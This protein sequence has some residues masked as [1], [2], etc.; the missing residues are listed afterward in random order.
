MG[1][2]ISTISG[3]PTNTGGTVRR[4][5]NGTAVDDVFVFSDDDGVVWQRVIDGAYRASWARVAS[6]GVD[7]TT[8]VTTILAH[9]DV[10]EIIFDLPNTEITIDGSVTGTGKHFRFLNGAK[11]VGSGTITGGHIIAD[12]EA[13][14]IGI[15]LDWKIENQVMYAKWFGAQ[16]D[17]DQVSNMGTND[18]PAIQKA[19]YFLYDP[20][21]SVLRNPTS[22]PT[23]GYKNL[24]TREIILPK[25]KISLGDELVTPNSASNFI[26]RGYGFRNTLIYWTKSG[27]GSGLDMIRI[28]NGQQ[29]K[30]V[31]F[32][33]TGSVGFGIGTPDRCINSYSTQPI[34]G[35][36]GFIGDMVFENIRA[37]G[38]LGAFRDGLCYT[39]NGINTSLADANNEQGNIINCYFEQ[40]QRHGLSFEHFN[41][42]WHR[43]YGGRFSGTEVGVNASRD[44]DT[45]GGSYIMY[46]S[47]VMGLNLTGV[48]FKMRGGRGQYV[49]DRISDEGGRYIIDSDTS[50]DAEPTTPQIIMR[51]CEIGVAAV[52]DGDYH[53]DCGGTSSSLEII[54]CYIVGLIRI[55]MSHTVSVLNIQGGSGQYYSIDYAGVASIGPN[56]GI[57]PQAVIFN[58]LGGTGTPKRGGTGKLYVDDACATHA[59]FTEVS[60]GTTPDFEAYRTAELA[61]TVP[62]TITNFLGGASGKVIQI[63]SSNNNVTLQH[64]SVS[65]PNGRD[66]ILRSGRTYRFIKLSSAFGNAWV[67]QDFQWT[68]SLPPLSNLNADTSYVPTVASTT[69]FVVVATA[70]DCPAFTIG[71]TNGG[72]D[73]LTATYLVTGEVMPLNLAAYAA[74]GT[75]FYFTG[76]T[77]TAA[78]VYIYAMETY[79]SA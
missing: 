10:K 70:A 38:N 17:Y 34:Y 49:L 41:S 60:G 19:V 7:Y 62:T 66:L 75:T 56:G 63:Y 68:Y 51:N 78:G 53:I 9:A 65:I 2:D 26:I 69:N 31:D 4:A 46:G 52:A 23:Q 61:Y 6:E 14:V 72:D 15:D 11:L 40:A 24:P 71:R 13:D 22:D 21:T 32:S 12:E 67:L 5:A 25:G 54:N 58:S 20:D 3:Y 76:I 1:V 79:I 39:C 57:T 28:V 47:C 44:D 45:A 8:E 27:S 42:T 29:G 50:A 73:V 55:R 16:G 64:G 48:L 37:Y 30:L 43:I 77:G 35:N 18:Q 74:N 33:I 36:Q 59:Q